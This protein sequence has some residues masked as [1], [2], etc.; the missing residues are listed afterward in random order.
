M[1][2]L[3]YNYYRLFFKQRPLTKPNDDH[4]GHDI[5]LK[6]VLPPLIPPIHNHVRHP[7]LSEVTAAHVILPG[8]QPL[9]FKL[10]QTTPHKNKLNYYLLFESYNCT[11]FQDMVAT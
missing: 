11:L 9:Q 8:Y 4:I 5:P 10:Q 7:V 1:A 6:L 2:L 3:E